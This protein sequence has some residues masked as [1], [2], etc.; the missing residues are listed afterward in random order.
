MA[1]FSLSGDGT[2]P[3]VLG[4]YQVKMPVS[5]LARSVAWYT[6]LLGL[7]LHREFVEGGELTGA[8]ML[9]PDGFVLS[10]RL[11]QRVP[12]EP[13][14]AGFDLFSLGVTDRADLETLAARARQLGSECSE[15][16]DRGVDGY[17]LDIADPDGVLV[18]FLAPAE[19]RSATQAID[20]TGFVGVAFDDNGVPAFYTTPRLT[21]S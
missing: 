8:V 11:R 3:R 16:A 5:D 17:A 10:A 6:T 9:H 20:A 15:I 12:G 21:S 4:I 18:R 7:T 14:F 1:D 13:S 19:N 2:P